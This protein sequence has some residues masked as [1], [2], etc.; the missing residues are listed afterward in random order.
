MTKDKKISPRIKS[1]FL[2]IKVA[3]NDEKTNNQQQKS[4]Q[5]LSWFKMMRELKE[6]NC[7]LD[8]I[9]LLLFHYIYLVNKTNNIQYQF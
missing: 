6:S 8:D 2:K 7:E 9:P 4:S 5:F 3:N 1:L